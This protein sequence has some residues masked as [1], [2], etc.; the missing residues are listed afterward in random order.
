MPE[1]LFPADPSSGPTSPASPSVTPT[2]PPLGATPP[3]GPSDAIPATEKGFVPPA[4]DAAS[5]LPLPAPGC[6]Y[7]LEEEIGRGGMG[8]VFR[9]SDLAFHRTLAVKVLRED[10]RGQPELERRF[11]EE[12]QLTGQL[13]HPGIPPAHEVGVLPDGRPF[14]S[15][16]LIKGRTLAEL[17]GQRAHTGEDLPRFLAVFEQ[18]CQT[19]A[20]AHS[21]GVIHRDLK[22]GNVMVGAFGEVQVMDWGL[23]KV[24]RKGPSAEPGTPAEETTTIQTVRSEAPG[25]QSLAGSVLGTPSFMAPEQA[26]GEVQR[27]DERCDVFGLGA[28]LCVILTGA[29]PYRGETTAEVRQRAE[30][31]DLADAHARLQVCGA[32][33]ELVQLALRCLSREREQRPRDAGEVAAAMAAYQEGVRERLRQAEQEQAAAEVRVREERKRRRLT[34][35]LAAAGLLL[36]SVV[37]GGAWWYQREQSRRASERT[38]RRA[39]TEREVTTALQRAGDLLREGWQQTDYPERWQVTLRLASAAVAQAE[40]SLANGEPTEELHL[41]VQTL[42]TQTEAAARYQQLAS[43][44]DRIRLVP[45]ETKEGPWL[46]Q[47]A[48][49]TVGSTGEHGGLGYRTGDPASVTEQYARAFREHR[50]DVLGPDPQAAAALLASHPLREQLLAALEDWG[51]YLPPGRPERQQLAAVVQAADPA[52]NAFRNRWREA[53]ARLDV[54]ELTQLATQADVAHLPPTALAHLGRDLR[55]VGANEAAIGLLREALH[56]HPGDFWLYFELAT[57][58]FY[59]KQPRPEDAVRYFTAA[60]A[61]RSGSS[62]AH[63]N[64]GVALRARGE[65]DEALRCQQKAVQCDPTDPAALTNLG[66]ALHDK[67]DVEGAFAAFQAALRHD[68]QFAEAHYSL[69]VARKMQGDLD[70]AIESFRAAT[71]CAPGFVAAHFNLGVARKARGDLPG[72]VAAY[73]AALKIEPANA[74]VLNNLGAAL[75]AQNDW[76]GAVRAYR[77][78]AKGAPKIALIH[79][80]LGV[81]LQHEK[82]VKGAIRAYRDALALEP[83]AWTQVNLGVALRDDGQAE[84][85]IA[86]FEAALR[87][88]PKHAAAHYNLGLML[89]DK[90][91]AERAIRCWRTA[92]EIDPKYALAHYQLGMALQARNDLDGAIDCFRRAAEYDPSNAKVHYNLGVALWMKKEAEAA[93]RC[94][95]TALARD[96]QLAPAHFNLALALDRQGQTE[97]ALEHYRA[98]CAHDAQHGPAHASAGDL[99]MQRGEFAAAQPYLRRAVGLFSR[100]DPHFAGV[101][102]LLRQCE[103][104][105]SLETK[106]T[107][108]LKGEAQPADAGERLALAR[109][110]RLKRLPAT[111]ARLAAEA[112]AERPELAND[113]RRGDRYSAACLSVLAAVGQGKDADRLDDKER[114]RLRT[115]ALEWLRADLR[116]WTKEA[117][118]VT[119]QTRDGIKRALEHWRK[120]PDL[121]GVREPGPL[122]G[123]PEPERKAWRQLWADGEALL[124]RMRELP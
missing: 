31:G 39:V 80:N 74:R 112:F 94:W 90:K 16:K 69:G 48:N 27:L 122:A 71:A 11:L 2:S 65:I 73:Q 72:A 32:D 23:A 104:M 33:P 26:R 86:A 77:A 117:E 92:I 42:R 36:V 105:L 22:P 60:V 96:A 37:G 54:K 57:A 83:D 30:Q 34:A 45:A 43:A 59:L 75:Q 87:I 101:E 100:D 56:K 123:L 108:I 79:H 64:L 120:N 107:A 114:L 28:I 85:A 35:A 76:Q 44:L 113:F 12:A 19:I 97:E 13:Q 5:R 6:R 78:A 124:T 9:A 41:R 20:Y 25:L 24:L 18:V 93:I 17:L 63:S 103:Q 110:C 67:G 62:T 8:S 115:Q 81:A 1:P 119:P 7:R 102:R 98:A 14:F 111:G 116:L 4:P 21:R 95:R 109:V 3:A 89:N 68:P 70:G 51:T 52:P 55:L 46:T 91:D 118:N 10:Q 58:S 106:L 84:E 47:R 40:G 82:D 99:L 29:P 66:I 38:A 88:E 15:M 121:A 49:R 53:R 61:L 50:L